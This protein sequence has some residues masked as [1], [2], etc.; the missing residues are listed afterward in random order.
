MN[1]LAMADEIARLVPMF[2]QRDLEEWKQ[3]E[4]TRQDFVADFPSHKI[5]SLELDEYV[6]GK[7]KANRSFCYRLEREMDTFGKI[8]GAFSPKFGVYFGEFGENTPKEYRFTKK[9]GNNLSAAFASIK[10]AIVDLIRAAATNDFAAIAGNALSPMFKGKILFV[11]FPEKFAPIY[12]W[13]HLEHFIAALDLDGAFECE[14]DMQQALME[15]RATWPKLKAQPPALYMRLLYEVF[16]HPVDPKKSGSAAP[17]IPMLRTAI[18]GAA[19]IRDMPALPPAAG[20]QP[21]GRGKIDYEARQKK[22]KRT[23]DRGELI[24][25]ALEKQRLIQGG[26]SE[27]AEKVDHVAD[28]EDGLGYDILSFEDDGT[29]RPI[30]VKATTGPNLQNG[31]Y[32]SANELEKSAELAN[33]HLYIVFSALSKSPRVF[34][35]KQPNLKDLGLELEPLIYHVTHSGR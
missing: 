27:L 29:E 10:Q 21:T 4:Q 34:T 22:T 20:N 18:D 35:M 33:Y 2:A 17:G 8:V 15:Y 23:G 30:E 13:Q 9:W 26:K 28:S 7:G 32:L 3:A 14:A 1:R 6:I 31:F 11:Y 25:L 5:L 16:G 19:F 24:V 12:A